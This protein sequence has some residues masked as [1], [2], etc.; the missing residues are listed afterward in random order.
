MQ[1]ST[2]TITMRTLIKPLFSLCMLAFLFITAAENAQGQDHKSSSKDIWVSAY[3]ASWNHFA[4][5]GGNWGSLPAGQID[6]DALTHLFY[7]AFNVKENGSLS[8]IAPY[9]N[10]SPDRLN[11]I[12]SAAHKA[13]K[14]V[15]FTVG[16]WGNHD[17]FVKALN[18]SVC[19]VFINNLIRIL[20]T[21]GFDGIDIDLEPIKEEDLPDFRVFI[22]KLHRKLQ[23]IT[24]RRGFTPLLTVATD[25]QPEF[26]AEV[27]N[28][29]N[30]INLMTYDFSGAWS[31]WVSWHNSAVYSGGYMFPGTSRPLPSTDK[32]VQ[33]Y[34]EAGVP[35]SK[36]GIGIDFYGYVWSGGN[37]TS[38]GGVTRP[39]QAWDVPPSVTDNVPYHQIMTQYFKPEYYHWDEKTKAA[40]LSI[41]LPGSR[42]DKF[43]SY[44][45]ER[46]IRSK[47]DYVYEND[48][49]GVIIWELGGGYREKQPA[50]RRD[51]LLQQVQ[52]IVGN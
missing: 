42:H 3:M 45:D 30:Q 9:E 11:A 36:L 16:G 5:P 50:G 7:F 48:L 6:W 26:F 27:H 2:S 43:I 49:G 47:L 32:R 21:W 34:L 41:D 52:N 40:Y 25:S 29:F 15:L 20:Q 24:T 4:P 12:V 18:P 22:E 33:A 19:P 35:A 31:G 44:D 46:S 8:E 10:I 23:T 51:L 1:Y 37:G 39:G 28:K 38:T 13:G 17:A 14:P